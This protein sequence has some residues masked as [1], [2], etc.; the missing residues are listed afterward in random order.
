VAVTAFFLH[1]EEQRGTFSAVDA[2]HL[3]WLRANRK[4]PVLKENPTVVFLRL[5]DADKP[6]AE[7]E[8]ESWPL[9]SGDWAGVIDELSGY[10]PAV[11]G[12]DLPLGWGKDPDP[13]LAAACGKIPGMVAGALAQ[14]PSAAAAPSADSGDIPP[15]TAPLPPQAPANFW[16]WKSAGGHAP[17]FGGIMHAKELAGFPGAALLGVDLSDDPAARISVDGTE[18]RVPLIFEHPSQGWSPGLLLRCLLQDMKIPASQVKIAPGSGIDLPGG[19]RIPIDDRG[20][21]TFH[22]HPANLHKPPAISLDNFK[23]PKKQLERFLQKNDE[24][25]DV[26][27]KLRGGLLLAGAD[28]RASQRHVLPDGASVSHAKLSALILAALQTGRNIRPAPGH[29]QLALLGTVAAFCL[30]QGRQKRAGAIKSGFIALLLA[31]MASLLTF[32][33]W[34]MW[35]P[36]PPAALAIA[37]STLL[38]LA[39]PRGGKGNANAG[40]GGIG[41][42]GADSAG[43]ERNGLA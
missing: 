26:L 36:L 33:S 23:L 32:Q 5:D 41:S 20:I 6:E 43:A 14:P 42:A 35:L 13:L 31:G 24:R 30:F 28:D 18:C 22:L 1:R 25:R 38:C 2:K 12:V 9:S 10:E 27:D 15:A 40:A 7:R 37:V 29:I 19:V 3:H 34:E 21:Y 39:L 4:T 11:L 8:F 16:F 17:A